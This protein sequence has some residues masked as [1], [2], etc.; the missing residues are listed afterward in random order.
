MY[1]RKYI[2]YK[3]KYIQLQNDIYGGHD[4]TS[5]V[6]QNID[7]QLSQY[8]EAKKINI[9]IESRLE[10]INQF[11]YD[12]DYCMTNFIDKKE[13]NKE[14]FIKRILDEKIETVIDIII[15]ATISGKWGIIH[16]ICKYF[17]EL[18]ES[19]NPS[20]TLLFGYLNETSEE[21]EHVNQIFTYHIN[22]YDGTIF[23]YLIRDYYQFK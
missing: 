11:D 23:H 6:L 21:I 18:L 2:K 8:I 15:P 12:V 16:I 3:N 10:L 20:I 7:L 14:K 4:D 5:T 19:N 13:C 17:I 9:N 1:N 22:E